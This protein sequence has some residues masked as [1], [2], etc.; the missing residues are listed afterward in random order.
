M[1]RVGNMCAYN[2]VIIIFV[3]ITRLKYRYA[4]CNANNLKSQNLQ[5]NLSLL[6][7][8]LLNSRALFSVKQAAFL[9]FQLER[10]VSKLK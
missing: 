9:R 3:N 5:F 2:E 4:F 10:W 1:S 6:P 8:L 7:I